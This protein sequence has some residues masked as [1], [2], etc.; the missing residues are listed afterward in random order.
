[1]WGTGKITG[2]LGIGQNS[3]SDPLDITNNQNAMTAINVVNNNTG[4][5][6]QSFIGFNN[7]SNNGS[8]G[9]TGTGYTGSGAVVPANTTYVFAS[10]SGGITLDSSVNAPIKFWVNG[11]QVASYSSGLQMGAPTGGDKGVGTINVSGG[12]YVNGVAVSGGGGGVTQITA[13]TG[14]T[15]TP[16]PITGTGSVALT[17]PVSVANGGYGSGT[18]PTAGQIPI[19][20]SATSYTP[21]TLSGDATLASTGALTVTKTSGTAF[22]ALATATVPLSIANGGRGSSTAPTA[23]QIDVAQSGTA[24]A[25]V[26]MSGAA[27]INSSGVITL[28][29]P[30]TLTGTTT[31]VGF[32]FAGTPVAS[33]I[34]AFTCAFNL[35]IPA[36]FVSPTSVATCGTNPS[37]ADAYTVKVNGVSVGTITLSTSCVATLGTASTTTCAAGQR[38]EIDAPAT[39]SGKDV[40]ITIAATR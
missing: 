12:F 26:T 9:L 6:A 38:M 4:T 13:G 32:N 37:E 24:F 14:I 17:T 22:T 19:A 23:G 39:V 3:G 1:V 36:N 30:V 20:Q 29:T 10:A 21:N 40:A 2:N 31:S 35:T 7:G 16:S 8:F 15:L 11:A 5:S 25:G 18:A 34:A 28:T 33:S 27:T